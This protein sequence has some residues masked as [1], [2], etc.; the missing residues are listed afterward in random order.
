MVSMQALIGCGLVLTGILIESAASRHWRAGVRAD[1]PGSGR[2]PRAGGRTS[3][4]GARSGSA[5][6]GRSIDRSVRVSVPSFGV[7][8]RIST[9]EN[10]A[11][12]VGS[13]A[14]PWRVATVGA[15]DV[16][17]AATRPTWIRSAP[18][19]IDRLSKMV[20]PSGPADV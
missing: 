12:P 8:R 3:R 14:M 4:G 6:G 19:V 10:P 11:P 9:S 5:S 7:S 2:A 15:R 13:A 20:P 1:R 18:R 17:R 16:P